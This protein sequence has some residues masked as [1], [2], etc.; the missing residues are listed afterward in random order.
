MKKLILII[1]G[2]VF[3]VLVIF[4]NVR[5]SKAGIEVK[6]RLVERRKVISLVRA[7]GEVRA[8]NQVEIGSDVMGRIVKIFVEEGDRVRKGDT[9]CI[10][11]PDVYQAKVEQL[12]ARLNADKAKFEKAEKDFRRA[13]ALREKGLISESTFEEAK[14]TYNTLLSQVVADSFALEE[15]KEDLAKTVIVS[16]VD[17]QVVRIYKEEGEMTVVGTIN[18]PGTIIMVVADLSRMEVSALVDESE[19]V[20]VKPGQ[21]VKIKIDAYPDEEFKGTIMRIGG[22]P[23]SGQLAQEG[24]SYPVEIEMDSTD[25]LLLP[26]MS[27]MCEIVVAEKEDALVVPFTAVGKKKV[28]DKLKDVVFCVKKGRAVLRPVKLGIAGDR[29]VEVLEGVSEGDTVIVGPFRVLR[30]LRGGEEVRIQFEKEGERKRNA[31]RGKRSA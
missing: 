27:A 17:G 20:R 2:I 18:S 21:R 3:L 23:T 1:G 12:K 13:V 19:I 11:D 9:L 6:C 22:I 26:G 28:G 29:F 16:P 30:T 25:K 14:S 24:V 7:E 4:L 8:K 15:A 10:I 5:R 31:H